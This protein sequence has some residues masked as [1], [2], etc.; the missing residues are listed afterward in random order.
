[1][2]GARPVR[3]LM[4]TWAI[5][6]KEALQSEPDQL[7]ERIRAATES[8]VKRLSVIGVSPSPNHLTE[9]RALWLALSDLRVL[10][11]AFHRTR[12]N[13]KP[14]RPRLRSVALP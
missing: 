5:L 4:P 2:L 3:R 6:Y 14:P 12:P 8:I 10:K 9:L 1:M 13:P 7:P 11:V